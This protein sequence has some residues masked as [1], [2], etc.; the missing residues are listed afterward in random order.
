MLELKLSVTK[1]FITKDNCFIGPHCLIHCEEDVALGFYSGLGPRC[2]VYTHGSFLP[3]TRGYPSKFEPVVIEDFVWI[4]M[5]VTLLPGTY[6]ES[7]C[8]I[9]PGVTVNSRIK[10]NTLLQQNYEAYNKF[11]LSR[12][13]KLSQKNNS[14]YHNQILTTYFSSLQVAFQRTNNTY[15]VKNNKYIFTLFPDR[16]CI[17]LKICN[18]KKIT[19]DLE[20]FYT[21]EC[22]DSLHEKF[23]FFLRRKYGLTLRTKYK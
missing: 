10:S 23:I 1:K 14:Y 9:N 2:T 11:D 12:L 20:H 8:I 17:E 4:G 22:D 3:V 7:C 21:D 18:K 16:N 15:T 5:V 19:Y 6:I 13:R